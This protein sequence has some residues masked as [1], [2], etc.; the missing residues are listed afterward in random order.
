MGGFKGPKGS[1]KQ[2]S[3]FFK[4]YNIILLP[5]NWYCAQVLFVN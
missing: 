2:F 3:T 5:D 4:E 1:T